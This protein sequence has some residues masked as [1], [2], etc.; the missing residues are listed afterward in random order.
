MNTTRINLGPADGH[1][2]F[3][4]KCYVEIDGDEATLYSYD[5]KIMT[6]HFDTKTVTK[7]EAYNYSAT[8][9]RHQKAFCQL[10]NIA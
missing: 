7:H 8:T 10:Y 3:Y 2:S 5:T 1:K 6:Y 4:G 9:K